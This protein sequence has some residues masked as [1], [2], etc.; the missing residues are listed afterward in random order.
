MEGERGA[1]LAFGSNRL[2]SSAGCVPF[3]P[4]I[5]FGTKRDACSMNVLLAL[6][7][8]RSTTAPLGLISRGQRLPE[9]DSACAVE[10]C[11]LTSRSERRSKRNP[12]PASPTCYILRY[13]LLSEEEQT[14]TRPVVPSRELGLIGMRRLRGIRLDPFGAA[15]VRRTERGLIVECRPVIA[16]RFREPI[17]IR[18]WR[19]R[20]RSCRTWS[21]AT[22]RQGR[23]HRELWCRSRRNAHP[24]LQTFGCGGDAVALRVH[25]GFAASSYTRS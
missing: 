25:S 12:V 18:R 7:R 24:I 19:S 17:R 2:V 9:A 16:S 13:S 3:W 20:L 10:R 22:R 6:R 8:R 11:H 14:R 4:G 1:V 23:E 15:T 21:A 5:R